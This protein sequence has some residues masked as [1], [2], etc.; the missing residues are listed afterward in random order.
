MVNAELVRQLFESRFGGTPRLFRAPG[1]VNLIGEHTDYNDGFVM[2]VAIDRDTVVA[3]S[4]RADTKLHIYSENIRAEATIDLSGPIASQ[5][6]SWTSYVE[7]VARVLMS[8]G[9]AIEGAD[10]VILSDLPDGAGLSSSAALELSV[11]T[12]LSQLNGLEIGCTALALACQRAEHEYAGTRSGIMD[13]YISA[14]GRKDHALLIDCRALTYKAISIKSDTTTWIV[15]DTKVKHNLA[16]SAYN[17]RRS[18]CERAVEIIAKRYPEVKALRDADLSMLETCE[19][20]LD[21]VLFRRARHVIAENARTLQAAQAL[22]AGRVEEMGLLMLSSHDSLR[23]DYEVT[24]PELDFLVEKA[25]TFEGCLGSRMTGGGFGG[26]TIS[27]VRKGSENEF[28]EAISREYE[29]AFGIEAGSLM[30][31]SAQGAHEITI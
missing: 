29:A 5:T 22:S 9:H 6:G 21:D 18:Q 28:V 17:E 25:R 1:R 7:G 14:A 23:D 20:E 11:A 26:C 8:Q 16:S 3:A 15:I 4:N 10:I 12:A 30:I 31:Q 27:L 2:P 13:Q 24:S 19:G